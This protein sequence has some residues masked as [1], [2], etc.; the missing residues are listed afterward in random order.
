[1]AESLKKSQADEPSAGRQVGDIMIGKRGAGGN[2][3][4]E[5]KQ[6]TPMKEFPRVLE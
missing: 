3:Q 1:M 2:F 6:N 4:S 5:I